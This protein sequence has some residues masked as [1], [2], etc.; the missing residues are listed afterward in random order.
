MASVPSLHERPIMSPSC[1]RAS[2]KSAISLQRFGCRSVQCT[3]RY[4]LWFFTIYPG[5]YFPIA[6]TPAKNE[7]RWTY[8][9]PVK[10]QHSHKP[11]I[12]INKFLPSGFHVE[13]R[14]VWSVFMY[15]L[16]AE[17][18]RLHEF[19]EIESFS[20]VWRDRLE[21]IREDR[22]DECMNI[23]KFF[24]QVVV[25]ILYLFCFVGDVQARLERG[26]ARIN[27]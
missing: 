10:R 8:L 1:V 17:I 13:G 21:T 11:R 14:P 20:L 22:D 9:N 18:I 7:F 4:S 15:Y 19:I 6:S 23:R 25:D 12:P 16:S 27:H 26:P 24:T 2:S 3:A 5:E